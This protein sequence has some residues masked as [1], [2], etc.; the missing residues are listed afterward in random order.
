MLI[1]TSSGEVSF[2][3][4]SLGGVGVCRGIL[5]PPLTGLSPKKRGSSSSL[6]SATVVPEDSALL[7]KLMMLPLGLPFPFPVPAVGVLLDGALVFPCRGVKG[8]I[9]YAVFVDN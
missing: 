5:A 6:T 9:K 4:S 8:A 3:D 7:K 2:E 1:S